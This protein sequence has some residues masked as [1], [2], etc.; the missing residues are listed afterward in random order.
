LISAAE[1]PD[2]TG[3]KTY[4]SDTSKYTAFDVRIEPPG[5]HC[6]QGGVVIV[7]GN[8]AN[9]DGL[10]SAAEIKS[11]E[12]ACLADPGPPGLPLLLTSGDEPSGSHCATGGKYFRWGHDLDRSGTLAASEV[13]G[14]AYLCNGAS[15]LTGVNSLVETASE[16]PGEHCVAGGLS[17]RSGV[18]E[19][20]DG[21]LDPGEVTSTKYV[22]NGAPGEQGVAGPNVCGDG[23]AKMPDEDCDDGNTSDSDGCLS[24]CVAAR[25]GDG[26]VRA[27]IEACDDG[28]TD[29]SDGC[30][31]ACTSAVCGDGIT[32]TGPEECDDGNQVETDGCLSSCRAASCGDGFLQN[33]ETCDDGN[34]DDWDGCWA[35]V[36]SEF[37]VE[38]S[39]LVDSEAVTTAVASDGRFIVAWTGASAVLARLHA[40]DGNPQGDELRVDAGE[41]AAVHHASAAMTRDGRFVIT[42]AATRWVAET[43]SRIYARIYSADGVVEGPAFEVTDSKVPTIVAETPVVAMAEDGRFAIAWLMKETSVTHAVRARTYSPT[44]IPDG[45]ESFVALPADAL[46]PAIGMADDRRFV[47]AWTRKDGSGDSG[48]GVYATCF[49]AD[50]DPSV[51]SF[52]VNVTTAGDQQAPAIGAGPDG[53][54]VIAWRGPD[55]SGAFQ[56]YAR[57]F[58]AGCTPNGG[59]FRVNTTG[60]SSSEGFSA[61]MSAAGDFLVAWGSPSVRAQRFSDSATRSGDELPLSAVSTAGKP[62]PRIAVAADGRFIAAWGFSV[63]MASRLA[64]DGT[65][66]GRLAW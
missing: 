21:I 8:D 25:C 46:S 7:R 33:G 63:V 19:D 34:V 35:C 40:A 58:A 47:V 43:E 37:R 12:Y 5:G 30:T 59:E 56:I 6:S 28:N 45:A 51:S 44:G 1:T 31:N 16:P 22:C 15:G 14:S 53:R 32:E 64:A 61:G 3:S 62:G 23:V 66:R 54:F 50:G 60:I 26:I 9:K 18:D 11:S 57:R 4:A 27:G 24:T 29:D 65:M 20:G 55:G 39:S 42:W 13:E 2:V 36:P 52:H 41:F 49:G 17:V 10:L 38:A 48:D